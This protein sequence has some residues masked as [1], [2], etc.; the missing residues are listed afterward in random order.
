[1]LQIPTVTQRFH[2]AMTTLRMVVEVDL[3]N[4]FQVSGMNRIEG[5]RAREVNVKLRPARRLQAL[6]EIEVQAAVRR[7][8][9]APDVALPSEVTMPKKTRGRQKRLGREGM[10]FISFNHSAEQKRSI[11]AHRI[12]EHGHTVRAHAAAFRSNK[13]S[14]FLNACTNARQSAMVPG[15]MDVAEKQFVRGNSASELKK[16]KGRD[17]EFQL[18]AAEGNHHRT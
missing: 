17:A 18:D 11:A 15:L 3:S 12:A 1:L 14:N 8:I 2:N 5:I 9:N 16:F 10:D 4:S 7:K 13:L 6:A